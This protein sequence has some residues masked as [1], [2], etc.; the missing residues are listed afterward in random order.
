MGGWVWQCLPQ[1]LPPTPV[2]YIEHCLWLTAPAES[3]GLTCEQPRHSGDQP[4][5]PPKGFLDTAI[6]LAADCRLLPAL[7]TCPLTGLSVTSH[8][9]EQ[10]AAMDAQV[11]RWCQAHKITPEERRL[12]APCHH[13]ALED[14]TCK[15]EGFPDSCYLAKPPT[16]ESC[17]L[18]RPP[19]VS[20]ACWAQRMPS[21]C[22]CCRMDTQTV[23]CTFPLLRQGQSCLLM[24][25][26][27][28]MLCSSFCPPLQQ[29]STCCSF[30]ACSLVLS[31]PLYSWKQ[32][33]GTSPFQ[34]CHVRHLSVC[35]GPQRMLPHS[36]SPFLGCF[37]ASIKCRCINRGQSQDD[38]SGCRCQGCNLQLLHD[39]LQG[40]L[41]SA[42]DGYQA[43][44][45]AHLDCPGRR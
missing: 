11:Q 22:A 31:T 6:L 16:P 34:P 12:L 21:L 43:F 45:F 37:F 13:E 4:E 41:P 32:R 14:R 35:S 39:L 42:A 9:L 3:H 24:Q 44:F 33:M 23:G 30:I 27:H 10:D 25:F 29:S 26:A 5:G 7:Q 2:H 1:L 38:L 28:P 17:Q 20:L 19:V 36:T 18:S 40:W 8:R 15:G